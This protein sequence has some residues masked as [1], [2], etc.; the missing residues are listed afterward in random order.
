VNV[1]DGVKNDSLKGDMSAR[2]VNKTWQIGKQLRPNEDQADISLQHQNTDEGSIFTANKGKSY[3]AQFTQSTWSELY[4]QS[5]PK[6]GTLTTGST[7]KGS[8]VNTKTFDGTISTSSYFTKLTGKGDTIKIKTAFW[9]NGYRL[10]GNFVRIYWKTNPEINNQYF[11]L[12]RRL[13]TEAE[14]RNI[15]TIATKSINGI[16]LK[17][18]DYEVKDSNNY[19]GVSFYRLVLV[20]NEKKSTYSGIIAIAPMP[21]K[22]NLLLWPNPTPDKFYV[23]LN[24][25][26]SVKA[27]A[28]WNSVGQQL[29]MEKVNGRSIIEFQGFIPGTYMVGFIS[30]TNNIIETKKVIVLGY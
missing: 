10:D 14:F 23:G 22:F 8:G 24:G 13:G 25:E 9:F 20:D 26:V 4:P 19:I 11:I 16:S 7:L 18:L 15:D 21:G 5:M 6:Q 12:Q 17:N 30:S 27:I 3:V 28:I 29:R 2:S 1:A